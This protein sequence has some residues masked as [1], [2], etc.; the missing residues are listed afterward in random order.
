MHSFLT[1]APNEL[2]AAVHPSRMPVMLTTEDEFDCWLN[3][4]PDRRAS[5]FVPIPRFRADCAGEHGAEGLG[6]DGLKRPPKTL[7]PPSVLAA[8]HRKSRQEASDE[9][10][11]EAAFAAQGEQKISGIPRQ[12]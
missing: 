10:G 4:S 12:R 2:I 6:E 3:G 8:A 11:A 1:T 5:S 9:D 7:R